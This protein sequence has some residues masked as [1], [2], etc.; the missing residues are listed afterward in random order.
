[1]CAVDLAQ[2][3]SRCGLLQPRQEP[4]Q[5]VRRLGL[6]QAG[7]RDGGAGGGGLGRRRP[8]Q[9]AAGNG[10]KHKE[11]GAGT[12]HVAVRGAP[13]GLVLV[14]LSSSSLGSRR[15]SIGCSV[16]GSSGSGHGQQQQPLLRQPLRE[17]QQHYINQPSRVGQLPSV[18]AAAASARL[19]TFAGWVGSSIAAAFFSSLERTSCLALATTDSDAEG[20]EELLPT[21]R[22][23]VLLM[24]DSEL[25]LR[26]QPQ[27]Q[28]ESS[29]SDTTQPPPMPLVGF[30]RFQRHNPMTERFKVLRFHHVEFWCGDATNTWKRFGW[31]L[32][33]HLVAKSDQT[34]GNQAYASY[35]LRSHQLVMAFTA[36]YSSKTD[37][38]G[39]RAPHPGYDPAEARRFTAAHGGLAVRAV[40]VQV[41]DADASFRTSVA[42]G[43]VPVLPPHRL[44]DR[45]GAMVIAEVKLYGDVVLR[46]VSTEDG[47]DADSFAGAFLPN[48]E[49][50]ESV[51]VSYG[52]RR[53]D[54][55]VGNVHSL[56]KA[57][58]YVAGFTGFHEFAEFTA[59]DVGTADSGLNSVVLASDNEAVLLPLNEP[60]FGTRRKSQIQTFLEHNEGPGLQHL[61]LSC[62]DIFATLK[63]MQVRS[64]LGGFEFMP[65]PPATYY[66]NLPARVGGALSPAQMKQ[67]EELGVLVDK[68][69]Q[70][71]LL[72][73]F[74][75]P[76]GDR[77]VVGF[78]FV[79]VHFCF[80][81]SSFFFVWLMKDRQTR[82]TDDLC[83]PAAGQRCS[84]RLSSGWGA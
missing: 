46:Y 51:P 10:T 73:I 44:Q 66:R 74:T 11:G 84:W 40:G 45:S 65:K 82:P 31:G 68:D 28:Q 42:H 3:G 55:A 2:L 67:C 48:Y 22:R 14:G 64:A 12:W 9:G 49:A 72:Q 50:V 41:A 58:K 1:M 19:G 79:C 53:L 5:V 59:E 8:G 27:Q 35:V 15:T 21:H 61:A 32:G 57:V 47:A 26:R 81:C 17:R 36:P 30:G 77:W 52:L 62:D 75:K 60:T 7:E 70:G 13:P 34:T 6:L 56:L 4:E 80:V 37:Q 33:M 18:G 43:A 83:L 16:S 54:H 69:D 39:S 78:L 20:E 25:A 76:L 38:A 71:V 23:G 29:D 63:E 24:E